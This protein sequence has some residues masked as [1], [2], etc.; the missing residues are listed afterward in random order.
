MSHTTPR[1]R[2]TLG[3]L[4]TL[5]LTAVAAAQE[6]VPRAPKP[7]SE[8]NLLDLLDLSEGLGHQLPRR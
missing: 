1:T 5:A 3:L 2:V 6:A 7:L 8:A 4:L